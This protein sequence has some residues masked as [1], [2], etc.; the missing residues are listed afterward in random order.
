MTLLAVILIWLGVIALLVWGSGLLSVIGFFAVIG[1]AF[2][3]TGKFMTVEMSSKQNKPQQTE[4]P[5]N[6]D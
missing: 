5:A 1:A 3:A 4:Q 6:R 2:W